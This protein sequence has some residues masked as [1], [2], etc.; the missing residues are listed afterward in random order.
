MLGLLA[1]AVPKP[2]F[3]NAQFGLYQL[4]DFQSPMEEGV[5]V[6]L[7]RIAVNGARRNMPPQMG[8]DGQRHRPPIPVDLHYIVSAWAKTAL[9]QQ[10]LLGW[11]IRMFEDV[12]ILPTGLLNLYGPEPDI[13]RPGETVELLLESLTLQDWNNLWSTTRS[14]PPLSVGYVA[15][16]VGIDSDLPLNQPAFVQTRDF[17]TGQ[18]ISGE[19]K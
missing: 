9:K 11:T 14:S 2:E 19:T 8:P 7:Y 3:A 5:S 1:D 10:R 4:A 16:M 17:K 18:A 6:Y 13:F 15:R 12:P